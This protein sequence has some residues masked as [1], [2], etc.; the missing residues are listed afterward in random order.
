MRMPESPKICSFEISEITGEKCLIRLHGR[1]DIETAV[2][3]HKKLVAGLKGRPCAYLDIDLSDISYLDDYGALVLY[4]LKHSL[5]LNQD[6]FKVINPPEHFA[7]TLLLVDFDFDQRCP[8]ASKR[9]G[10]NLIIQLGES[11]I[12]SLISL[13]FFISFIGAIFLAVPQ[14]FKKPKSLRFD[15]IVWNMKTTG[16]DAVPVIALISFLL[17][18]IM[19]F[20][21]SLQLQ[22]FGANIFVASLVALAMVSELGPIMTAI[23]VA[24]R[25]GSAYAAEISTMQISEEI[26]AL[27]TMGF[28]PII[29]LF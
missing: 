24:G 1:L 20:V 4:E 3:T 6:S 10:N 9:K 19:A 16:V 29:S 7:R 23:I 18:L 27:F 14:I 5:N 15:D 28:D 22:Q 26:D 21:S 8:L 11:T 12:D 25:S 13:K 17:G 2:D